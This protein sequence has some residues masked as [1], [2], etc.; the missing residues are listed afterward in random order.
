[1]QTTEELR[2]LKQ[3]DISLCG[4]QIMSLHTPPL[5]FDPLLA[6]QVQAEATRVLPYL[7]P[8]GTWVERHHDGR[9]SLIVRA[10]FAAQDAAIS[11]GV[12]SGGRVKLYEL[13]AK[14][15]GLDLVARF[16]PNGCGT[17]LD[18]LEGHRNWPRY[19]VLISPGHG[20]F[21]ANLGVH[22][23][24][25]IKGLDAFLALSEE[26][27]PLVLPRVTAAELDTDPRWQEVLPYCV[28]PLRED[29]RGLYY[30]G[31]GHR[32]TA[33]DF[34]GLPFGAGFVIKP[35]QDGTGGHQ[36]Y[37]CTPSNWPSHLPGGH[38]PH[39]IRA[40]LQRHGFML[41]QP[42]Y[43]PL[44]TGDPELPFGLLRLF[45]GVDLDTGRLV[46]L[47]GAL[48]EHDNLVIHGT[49]RTRTRLVYL[50]E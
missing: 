3:I 37:V 17:R 27:R 46:P 31:L 39:D 9:V 44:F 42:F 11:A 7:R 6:D 48:L 15:L 38:T 20:G 32:V 30:A 5:R 36:V 2:R 8:Q 25:I 21:D 4:D 24:P 26:Q 33:A 18:W 10:D 40:A 12:I 45:L 41:Y 23:H 35:E 34:A 28:A 1:M 43:P 13:E 49:P 19:C 29:K 14:P 16:D 22:R 50:P 47:G